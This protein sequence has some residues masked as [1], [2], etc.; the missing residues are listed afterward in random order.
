MNFKLVAVFC[1]I[2]LNLFLA[3]FSLDIFNEESSI[4]DILLGLL[5]HLIPNILLV[6]ATYVAAKNTEL[7]FT[8]F[9]VLGIAAT[10]F[11]RTYKEPVTFMIITLPLLAISLLLG[12][13]LLTKRR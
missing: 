12:A 9:L 8:L 11:F 6:I 4:G 2:L 7:G 1:A 5:I 10:I 13:H 3:L